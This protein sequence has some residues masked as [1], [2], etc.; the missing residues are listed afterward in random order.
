MSLATRCT[1]CGTV[2]RVVQDQLKVSEGWV[3]C[4]RCDEVFNAIESLFDLERDAPPEWSK[5]GEHEAVQATPDPETQ[6]LPRAGEPNRSVPIDGDHIDAGLAG[7]RGADA[8]FVLPET[9]EAI[10]S[11]ESSLSARLEPDMSA[12]LPESMTGV[13]ESATPTPNFLR[14]AQRKS[15]YQ[16]P[17]AR[18]AMAGVALLLLAGLMGQITHHFR[19]LVGARWPTLRPALTAWCDAVGCTV[20]ALRRIEDIAVESTTLTRAAGPDSFRFAVALRNRGKMVLALPS[21]EL[22]LTDSNGQLVARR[23]LGPQ[24][25]RGASVTMMPGT[26][27]ALQLTLA[28]GDSRVTGYTVEIFYP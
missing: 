21:L 3:R 11:E 24:D 10:S 9:V 13:E 19:D 20:D 16:G 18:L 22:S 23:T 12:D 6:S 26:E 8:G 7:S 14:E 25:F 1:S 2:F 27:A 17:R 15:R 4:G 5:R 28:T